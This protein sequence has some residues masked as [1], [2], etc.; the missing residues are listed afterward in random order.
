MESVVEKVVV[1]VCVECKCGGR[2]DRHEREER[3][4][5]SRILRE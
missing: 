3:G 5:G 1:G 2:G 4:V